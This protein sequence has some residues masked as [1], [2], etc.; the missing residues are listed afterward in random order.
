MTKK[1]PA[2]EWMIKRNRE[3]I[4]ELYA[5]KVGVLS[6]AVRLGVPAYLVRYILDGLPD[7]ITGDPIMYDSNSYMAETFSINNIKKTNGD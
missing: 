3:M 7:P 2:S 6:I 1:K 4:H 5:K